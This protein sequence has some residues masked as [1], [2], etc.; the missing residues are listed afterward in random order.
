MT[1]NSTT[2]I[3]DTRAKASAVVL[4]SVITAV[5]GFLFG[6]DNGSI[7]GSLTFLEDRFHLS[8]AGSG[9][10]TSCLTL[11]CIVGVIVAGRLSDLVGRKRVLVVVAAVFIIGA[12]GEAAAPNTVFL[13]VAR[14]LVGIGIG[15]ETTVAPLYISEIAP[16]RIRGRLVSFNQLANCVANLVIFAVSAVVTAVNSQAWNVD[17]GWR[18]IFI[19][20]IIPAILLVSLL[21]FIPESPRWLVQQGRMEDAR[22]ALDKLT[23]TDEDARTSLESIRSALDVEEKPRIAELF[24]PRYRRTLTITTVVALFQQFTGITAVF[25]YA[26]QIFKSAGFGGNAS[27]QSTVLVGGALVAGTVLSLW[28]IDKVG[29]RTLLIWGSVIMAV[30]LGGI[31]LLFTSDHPNGPLLIALLLAYV[32][33]WG[34]SFGTV[35]Y[36]LPGEMYPTRIRGLGSSASVLSQWVCTFLVSEF[37]P[38]MVAGIGSAITFGII[39]VMSVLALVF[40]VLFVKETKGRTLDELELEFANH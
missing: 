16:A 35:S 11:G 6:F 7:S 32:I 23:S 29:R 18:L 33:A 40:S 28:I 12:I 17:Y 1:T 39:A 22:V 5:G 36:V 30:L 15:L 24:Q 38:I 26:P 25:Y 37:F 31:A 9:W 3:T 8:A 27:I 2:S 14:I 20:G 34:C 10:V 19:I 13:V 4:V 21:R